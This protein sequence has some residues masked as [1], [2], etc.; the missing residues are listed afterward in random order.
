MAEQYA[1]LVPEPL[2]SLRIIELS[3]VEGSS[4]HCLYRV[5]FDM[6]V[7][8]RVASM[9]TGRYDWTYDLNWDGQRQ[10]WIITNYGEG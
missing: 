1:N 10:S 8:G 9:T 6:T 7:K 4:A 3:R 5:V 2:E